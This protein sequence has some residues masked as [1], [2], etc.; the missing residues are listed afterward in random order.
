MTSPHLTLR[1]RMAL[2]VGLACVFVALL[3]SAGLYLVT[4]NLVQAAQ[5]SKLSSAA[6]LVKER[7]ET[8]VQFGRLDPDDL[9]RQDV[10]PDVQVR[11][12]LGRSPLIVSRQFPADLPLEVAP[13]VYR[14]GDRYVLAQQ[15]DSRGGY[16]LLTLALSS[17]GTD[18]ARRAFLQATFIILPVTLLLACL[19]A[20]WAAGRMLR[21]VAALERSARLIGESGDLTRPVPGAGGQDELS[22]LANTLQTTFR[23]LQQT[24]ARE[25]QFLRA[26]AHDLRSPLAALKT[27]V[28]LSLSRE[29]GAERYRQDLQE[30]G[31]DLTRLGAL[32]EHL[33]LLARDPQTLRRVPVPLLEAATD[34]LDAAR[35]RYPDQDMD[36][37]GEAL[38]LPADRILIGQA[39]LN[40]LQNAAQH[41]AGAQVLLSVERAGEW[42]SLQVQDDGPGVDAAVLARLGEAFYRPDEARR[43]GGAGGGHG[44][45]LAIVRQVAELHGGSLELFSA[46]GQGFRALVRLPLSG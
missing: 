43:T 22:R 15:L 27:R 21:P 40:L 8:D 32:A 6:S 12:S 24:R 41:A 29:R 17:Q 2:S 3:L 16:A 30:V 23:Q 46:P 14:L 7:A 31:L 13:G 37:R 44:L 33:L 34:A 9:T 45:G 39:I 38:I 25:V 18:D 10:P 1:T 35:S 42:A 11:V 26:A 19:G 4:Q 5:L 28:A 36:V 20:W